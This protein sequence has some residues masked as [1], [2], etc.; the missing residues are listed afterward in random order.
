MDSSKSPSPNLAQLHDDAPNTGAKDNFSSELVKA[1]E[2]FRKRFTQQEHWNNPGV[3]Y[4]STINL[5]LAKKKAL[6]VAIQYPQGDLNELKGTF[7]DGFNIVNM[8]ESQY[9]YHP[10]CIRVLADQVKKD[11]RK[12]RTRW[13]TKENIMAGLKWLGEDCPSDSEC[14]RFLYFAGHGY[15]SGSVAQGS[16]AEGIIP[17]D[18]ETLVTYDGL[19]KFIDPGTVILDW[20]LNNH[21]VDSLSTKKIKLTVGS[22]DLIRKM[23][24]N[25]GC[26]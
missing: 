23:G 26:L 22:R 4:D 24:K 3:Q 13:P 1:R 11:N 14:K 19:G 16:D 8:L 2:T 6:V 10:S 25:F 20:E 9:G 21:L 18:Y 12:D 5:E 17:I 7:F 15:T